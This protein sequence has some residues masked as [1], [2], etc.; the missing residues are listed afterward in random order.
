MAASLHS[1]F[2]LDLKQIFLLERRVLAELP[3]PKRDSLLARISVVRAE[4]T[5]LKHESREWELQKQS[6]AMERAKL[7]NNRF[8]LPLGSKENYSTL[9]KGEPK[10]S[11]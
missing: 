11:H 4:Y 7:L 8:E 5:R 10:L 9:C 1:M 3:S 6:N 2:S